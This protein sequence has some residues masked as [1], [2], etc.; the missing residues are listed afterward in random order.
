MIPAVRLKVGSVDFHVGKENI[1]SLV[2]EESV[3]TGTCYALQFSTK[4]LADVNTLISLE[5]QAEDKPC[6]LSVGHSVED[7][8]IHW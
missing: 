7:G 1:S 3:Y 2:V 5:R 4:N 8:A 6:F